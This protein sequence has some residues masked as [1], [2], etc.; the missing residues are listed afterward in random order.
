MPEGVNPSQFFFAIRRVLEDNHPVQSCLVFL[1]ALGGNILPF[2][3]RSNLDRMLDSKLQEE[4]SRQT[5]TLPPVEEYPFS[6][7]DSEQNI[8]LEDPHAFGEPPLI[9]VH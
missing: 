1:R 6:E 9:K 7:E 2:Y 4:E 8:V 3:C 5:L